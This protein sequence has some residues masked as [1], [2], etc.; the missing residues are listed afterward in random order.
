MGS[1]SVSTVPSQAL[2]MMNN[3]FI[4][5]EAGE[6]AKRV[7]ATEKDS[8]RCIRQMYL[9]AFGRAPESWEIEE[10][11]QFVKAQ[12]AQYRNSPEPGHTE[13]LEEKAWADLGHVLFNSA[14]FIYVR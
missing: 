11:L 9:T 8:L 4:A 3:D 14:E 10:S 2:M 12:S 1:R 5:L 13:V 7:L 6:W